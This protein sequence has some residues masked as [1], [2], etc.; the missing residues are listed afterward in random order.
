[1]KHRALQGAAAPRRCTLFR[2]WQLLGRPAASPPATPGPA[3]TQACCQPGRPRAPRACLRGCCWAAPAQFHPRRP[4]SRATT[5]EFRR[6]ST[7]QRAPPGA[8]PHA[9]APARASPQ[10]HGAPPPL[11]RGAS[12]CATARTADG[13]RRVHS[14]TPGA[15]ANGLP[16]ALQLGRGMQTDATAH[17]G[18]GALPEPPARATPASFGGHAQHQLT[19][20]TPCRQR[21]LGSANT[22]ARAHQHAGKAKHHLHSLTTVLRPQRAACTTGVASRREDTGQEKRQGCGKCLLESIRRGEAHPC[23]EDNVLESAVLY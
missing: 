16:N 22:A 21:A 12:C 19:P 13:G 17:A 3:G 20:T 9:G 18:G 11:C 10:P 7:R 5:G 14:V 8:R 15:A 2:L 1:M 6:E 4:K 23:L